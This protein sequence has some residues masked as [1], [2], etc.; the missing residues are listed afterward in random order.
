[1]VGLSHKRVLKKLWPRET[2]IWRFIQKTL[3]EAFELGTHILWEFDRVLD[4]KVN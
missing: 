3:K 4:N 2:L 1:L